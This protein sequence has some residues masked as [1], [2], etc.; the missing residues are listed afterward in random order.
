MIWFAVTGNIEEQ[1]WYGLHIP[2]E[3]NCTWQLGL[4]TVAEL[5]TELEL[6]EAT[7]WNV[8][9]KN[10]HLWIA[11]YQQMLLKHIYSNYA[12]LTAFILA[13]TLD[14]VAEYVIFIVYVE[15]VQ[16]TITVPDD[17]KTEPISNSDFPKLDCGTLIP[18]NSIWN[19]AIGP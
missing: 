12:I 17:V 1:L 6:Y 7:L 19:C 8:T 14:N 18:V 5:L 10:N 11:N 3:A 4:L 9:V 15:A 16:F 13:N 2:D